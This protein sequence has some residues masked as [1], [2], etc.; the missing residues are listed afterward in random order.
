[1]G[2]FYM[3]PVRKRRK[4][5]KERIVHAIYPDLLYHVHLWVVV[6]ILDI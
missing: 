1:M 5:D 4:E 2:G 3:F 6:E